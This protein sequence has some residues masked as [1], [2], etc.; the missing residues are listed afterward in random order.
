MLA[1]CST[2]ASLCNQF[3][4]NG[5]TERTEVFKRQSD[6]TNGY[7]YVILQQVK[8]K[9]KKVKKFQKLKNVKKVLCISICLACIIFYRKKALEILSDSC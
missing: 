2:Q 1:D 9:L 4:L 7:K 3:F 8:Q 5:L 6:L